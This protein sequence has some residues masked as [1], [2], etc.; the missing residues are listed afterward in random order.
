MNVMIQPLG[1]FVFQEAEGRISI[2]VP[3]M[4]NHNNLRKRK[5][6]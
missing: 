6:E 3:N 5:S 4:V 1:E 2:I